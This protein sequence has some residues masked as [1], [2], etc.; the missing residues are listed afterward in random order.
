MKR[1]RVDLTGVTPILFAHDDIAKADEWNDHISAAK[2][3]KSKTPKGD[4]R[5]PPWTWQI[6]TPHDGQQLAIPNEY[7]MA[8]LRNAGA[9]IKKPGKGNETYRRDTQHSLIVLE[10]MLPV[11]SKGQPFPCSF[12]DAVR[13]LPFS[14]QAAKVK[15]LPGEYQLWA[16]RVGIPG[17][18]GGKK[19]VR[20]RLRVD[21]WT[22]SFTLE[23]DD[24]EI[25]DRETLNNIFEIAGRSVGIADWRPSSPT[26]GIFGRFTVAL[27]PTK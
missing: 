27:K 18:I 4:D 1:Y 6:R 22:T 13:Q 25:F 5:H 11:L 16:K 17:R 23:V 14:Q 7:V 10:P 9:K 24:E 15:A 8:C 2:D 21:H 19:H 26:P 20:V 3:S 12:M